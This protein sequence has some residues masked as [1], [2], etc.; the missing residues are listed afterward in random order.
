MVLTG[1]EVGQ[2]MAEG[3]QA[4]A[5]RIQDNNLFLVVSLGHQYLC[6]PKKVKGPGRRR[7]L[8]LDQGRG[9]NA[10]GPAEQLVPG[11]EVLKRTGF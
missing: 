7:R 2:F 9:L 3:G 6:V 1:Q 4:Q 5:C 10:K 11:G 8:P